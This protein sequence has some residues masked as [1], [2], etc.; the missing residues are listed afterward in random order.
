MGFDLLFPINLFPVGNVAYSPS[1]VHSGSD[2]EFR[3]ATWAESGP[4]PGSFEASSNLAIHTKRHRRTRPDRVRLFPNV[5]SG[6]AT[7]THHSR[8]N[9]CSR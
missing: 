3:S 1:L 2:F 4:K 8:R 6:P 5:P 7:Y 9:L